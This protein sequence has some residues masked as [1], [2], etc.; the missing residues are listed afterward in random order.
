MDL[1][2]MEL[3]RNNNNNHRN[4]NN[5][6]NRSP[7]SNNRNQHRNGNRSN[8]NHNNASC[9]HPSTYC[10]HPST[11]CH[12]HDTTNHSWYDCRLNPRSNNYDP[13]NNNNGN[14]NN[15]NNSN[16]NNNSNGNNTNHRYN[17]RSR[18]NNN[19][20]G[21]NISNNDNHNTNNNNSN[22]NCNYQNN[23]NNAGHYHIENPQAAG[24]LIASPHT[25][26]RVAADMVPELR[27]T[28]ATPSINDNNMYLLLDTGATHSIVDASCLP[29]D[30]QIIPDPQGTR[31]FTTKAGTFTT[32]HLAKVKIFFPELSPQRAF[33]DTLQIENNHRPSS[34]HAILGR[35][36]L[37]HIG[38]G[39]DFSLDPPIIKLD[40]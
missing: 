39:F 14:C 16:R 40:K 17:T 15:N 37:R 28:F 24:Q 32:T 33:N 2:E 4:N 31:T 1:E 34:F 9:H 27:F 19:N 10:H 11:Y 22:S 8:N 23:N 26:F 20:N 36:M 21:N 12:R 6:N 5:Q 7:A 38:I 13:N 3:W 25:T 18:N 29:N 30:T 35:D